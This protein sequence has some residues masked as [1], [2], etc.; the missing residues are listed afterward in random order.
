MRCELYVITDPVLGCGRSHEE[1]TRRAINGG[2]DVVQL[3]DKT[4][5][6]RDLLRAGRRMH[7]ITRAADVL[8]IVNDRVD[9]ALACSADGVHLGQSDLPVD[10]ARALVPSEFII[11]VSV[12]HTAEAVQAVQEGANYVAASPVFPTT[13]KL[14]AG[15]GCGIEGIKQIRKAVDVP[16][17]AVGGIGLNNVH[18][19]L[20]AGADGI[21]VISAVVSQPNIARA[22]Q[23]LKNRIVEIKTG[24]TEQHRS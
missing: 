22:A 9:V 16:V 6:T 11:G 14:D 10:V 2:A 17:I 12:S 13:S 5:S 4:S 24:F 15:A 20:R 23:D 7:R 19:V 18:D 21:A 3:R 1:I 8:F